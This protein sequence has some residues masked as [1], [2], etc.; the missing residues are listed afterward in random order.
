MSQSVLTAEPG[1][2]GTCRVCGSKL[3]PGQRCDYCGAAYGEGNRCPHCR[4]V[5]DVEPDGLTRYR[6]R[7]CGGARVPVDDPAVVRTGR[8]IPVL[9]RVQRE[10]N[11]RTA[12]RVGAAVVGAF[13]ALSLLVTLFALALI[14]PGL[15]PTLLALLLVSVPLGVALM[16]WRRAQR[17]QRALDPALRQAWALVA[18]DVLG[19]RS[20]EVTATELARV[21]RLSPA[22]AEQLLAELSIHDFLH[23]RVTDAGDI[24]YSTRGERLRLPTEPVPDP[25]RAPDAIADPQTELA[26]EELEQEIQKGRA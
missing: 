24:A 1:P 3:G 19:S 10:R 22:M 6:C 5:A 18:S 9:Q 14:Q 15:L 16:A 2:A 23:A 4:A 7:V 17:H 21:M 25:L 26:L 13:G 12:W 20:G 8:E 11:R